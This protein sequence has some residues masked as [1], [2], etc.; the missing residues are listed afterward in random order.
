MSQRRQFCRRYRIHVDGD[1]RYKWIQVDTTYIR[2]TCIRCKRGIRLVDI[3]S[4]ACF[5]LTETVPLVTLFLGAQYKSSYLLTYT[6]DVSADVCLYLWFV[7]GS[8]HHHHHHHFYCL[9]VVGFDICL[10]LKPGFHNP[11]WRPELTAR[12]DG[13]PVSITRQFGPSTRVVETGLNCLVD[14]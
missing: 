13:W 14:N 7:P 3:G 6:I 10:W 9:F 4:C 11:S 8:H 12:V 5:S 1:R 2:A